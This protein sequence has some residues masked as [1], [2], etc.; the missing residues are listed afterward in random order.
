MDPYVRFYIGHISHGTP[1]ASGGGKTPQW[2][3]SYRL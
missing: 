1:P 3:V 2:K